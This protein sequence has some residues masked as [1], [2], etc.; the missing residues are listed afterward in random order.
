MRLRIIAL[1]C[2]A[3]WITVCPP[4]DTVLV[5]YSQE[6]TPSPDGRKVHEWLGTRENRW[7]PLLKQA[8]EA[9][10]GLALLARLSPE[11]SQSGEPLELLLCVRNASEVPR[12]L[13]WDRYGGETPVVLVRGADGKPVPLTPAGLRHAAEP[14]G[15]ASFTRSD[16]LPGEAHAFMYPLSTDFDLGRPGTYTVLATWGRGDAE[17]LLVANPLTFTRRGDS[18]KPAEG[19]AVKPPVA[20]P[21]QPATAARPGDEDWTHLVA[22]AGKPRDGCILETAVSPYSPK[23]VHLVASVVFL[24]HSDDGLARKPTPPGGFLSSLF[25]DDKDTKHAIHVGAVPSD[26]RVVLHDSHNAPVPLTDFGREVLAAR[27]ERLPRELREGDAI[28]TWFPLDEMF[29]LRSGEDYTVL[30]ALLGQDASSVTLVS[31]PQ[32]VHVPELAIA[33]LTR[34]P[35]GSTNIWRRLLAKASTGGTFVSA[36]CN[37]DD[38]FGFSDRAL[39]ITLEN[40]LGAPFGEELASAETTVLVRDSRGVPV[41]PVELGGR[42]GAARKD[43]LYRFTP[44]A[45]EIPTKVSSEAKLWVPI[46][47]QYPI[48]PGA[49]YTF[50]AAVRLKGR[51]TELL[52]AGPTTWLAHISGTDPNASDESRIETRRLRS[53]AAS[54]PAVAAPDEQWRT[55]SRFAGKC[56]GGLLLQAAISRPG[57]LSVTLTNQAREPIVVKKWEGS[58]GYEV[59][60]RGPSG[61]ATPLTWKGEQC[62]EGGGMLNSRQLKPRDT[63]V[64]ML[65]IGELFDMWVPGEYTA[66]ASLPVIGDVDAVLTAAPVKIRIKPKPPM[67]KN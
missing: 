20:E 43:N 51:R 45:G 66:L 1:A 44:V 15:L 57:E 10:N 41:F 59:L 13:A 55:L 54:T 56:Y 26:Y 14:A 7:G 18:S 62:F 37:I 16:L 28:G 52:V 9:K 47:Q 38:Q 48:L 42:R 12:P 21:A 34:P 67:P 22:K 4:N 64:T 19:P 46:C 39:K 60:V 49:R 2:T 53:L 27:R 50:M 5:A 58:S 24:P 63:L 36:D 31:A 6:D 25:S 29:T 65:P 33:G 3:A 17:G 23:A 30:V 40:S 11:P 61:L 8:G 32:E 35:Y